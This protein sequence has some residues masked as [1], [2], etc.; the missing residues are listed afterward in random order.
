[1]L[2]TPVCDLLDIQHPIIQAGM[3]GFT[4]AELVA[5]VTNAGGMGSLGAANRPVDDLRR[6][7]ARIRD[8]TSG[9]FAVNHLPPVLNEEAFA[10]TLE[11]KPRVVSMALADPGG[12]AQ[13]VHDAG[14]LVMQQVHTVKQAYE[15]AERGVDLIVAQGSEAG[16]YGGTVAALIPQVVD[17][18]RPIPVI[19]AG[20]IHDGRGLAAALILGAQGVNIGT[21]FLATVEAPVGDGWKQA[22]LA[23]AS[24][25][26][27]KV[28]VWNDIL[29]LPGTAG[30]GTVPRAL[31]TPFVDEWARRRDDAKRD[32][33]RL[34]GEIMAA[35]RERRFHEYVPFA[36]QTAGAIRDIRPAADVVRDLIAEAES[37]LRSAAALV[38][39]AGA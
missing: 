39:A 5:A 25:D 35:V 4:S 17:A 3:G 28:D 2:R 29:P 37:A 14:S 10:A 38:S 12:L 31:R 23:A 16:G 27:V 24:E 30:Y 7:L 20:G 8:L 36:G 33:Q 1:M 22:I 34:Q 21:R 18:V 15:A 11:A 26:A 6:Q 19:A 32:S 9:S 13:R